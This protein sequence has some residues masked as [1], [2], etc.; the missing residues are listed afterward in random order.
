MTTDLEPARRLFTV[1]DYHRMTEM[2]VLRQGEPVELIRGEIVQTLAIGQAHASCVARLNHLLFERLKGRAALWPR[3]PVMIL[4][5]S[6]PQPDLVLLVW[7]DDLYKGGLPGP[8]HVALLI[9]VADASLRY[10]RHVKGPLYADAGVRDY[11]IVDVEGQAVEIY[12]EPGPR[13]FQHTERVAGGSPLVPLAF[14]DVT[15]AVAD[16]FG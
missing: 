4:P 12:R 7:R 6:E 3:G 2:G 15:L 1:S 10:D 8:Q 16:V 13:G 11:W 5:S 9:E 14:P